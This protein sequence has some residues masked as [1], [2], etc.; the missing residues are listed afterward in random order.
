MVEVRF[1]VNGMGYRYLTVTKGNL[2]TFKIVDQYYGSRKP[3]TLSIWDYKA[4]QGAIE[5][6]VV[7]TILKME[8]T[9]GK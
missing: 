3:G 8:D 7:E 4:K 6:E 1:S 2:D 5:E 9:N